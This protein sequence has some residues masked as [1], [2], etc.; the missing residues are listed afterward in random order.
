M[1]KTTGISEQVGRACLLT[2]SAKWM[3]P[4]QSQFV[5]LFMTHAFQKVFFFNILKCISA[6]STSRWQTETL[7]CLVVGEQYQGSPS[8][9][10][11][12]SGAA[13]LMLY[14][15]ER[16]LSPLSTDCVRP[17]KSS[18]NAPCTSMQTFPQILEGPNTPWV[19]ATQPMFNKAL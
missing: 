2:D 5:L 13:N 19:H 15:A 8:L 10:S 3:C 9:S 4:Q 7:S 16:Q 6:V 14:F 1:I 18:P 12:G 11:V 17:G